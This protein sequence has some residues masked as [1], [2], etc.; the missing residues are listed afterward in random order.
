MKYKLRKEYT[1]NPDLALKEIL[2]DRG[3]EDIES[4]LM[5]SKNC[6]LNPYDLENIEAGAQ[7]LLKHLKAN[8]NILIIQDC[9][10]DGIVSASILWLYIK[11][12]YPM[13]NLEFRVHEHKQHG[14]DDVIDWIEEKNKWQLIIVPD[15]GS[16]DI[17]EHQTLNELKIDCLVLDH[18]NQLYDDDGNPV[19]SNFANT[20]VINNQLSPNYLNKSLCG[21][22]VTY[23]FCEVLD[24]ILGIRRAEEYLDLVAL[25]EI[26]DVMDRTTSETNYLMLEGLAHIHNKGF[27]SLL[28]AQSFSLKE[29]AMPPWEGLTPI[30]VAFYIAPLLNAITRVGSL[31][32][33][34]ACFYC[35]TEPDRLM[36]STKR[37]AK[38]GDTETA[39]E[40]TARVGANA[41]SKQNRIKEKAMDLIDFKIQKY[42]LL[43]DNIIFIKI[44]DEDDIPQEMTGLI[45][46]AV[47]SKY[48]KPCLIGRASANNTFAGSARSN[49]NFE[50]LPS[51]KY[52][53]EQSGYFNYVAGHD[54][55][56]GHSID[57]NKIDDFLKYA[58]THLKASDFE[59]CYIVDYVL[60]AAED[61][62]LLLEQLAMHPEYFG[63]HIDEIKFII[64]NIP[65]GSIM[66]MG[67]NKDSLKISYN[68]VDYIKFKDAQFVEEISNNR[69]KN[70]IV[71]GRANL[72]NFMGRISVQVFIDDYEFEKDNR[73]YDF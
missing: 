12:I 44:D 14:L 2:Q 37:G 68:G 59:N 43:Q 58:N 19:V 42:D 53:L 30:D 50:G 21:A 35:F 17:S 5:P 24:D 49:S 41:K 56:F 65:L 40:Q 18:H 69:L 22:G 13:A 45:A 32:D 7:M 11:N 20:I 73:K 25:G 52:F 48:N 33:K 27:Q 62:Q 70:L 46:M 4:F 72:N 61:N 3:V 1:K 57:A 39:A 36:P 60:D 63:N 47:V 6:E 64:K 66:V 67:A 38:P 10:T 34:I 16:Y 51:L 28:A 15:A 9:D 8:N 71:Y 29:K 26:A 23:K 54:A 55:A 31:Q